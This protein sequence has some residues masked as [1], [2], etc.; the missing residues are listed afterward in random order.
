[1]ST[2]RPHRVRRGFTL[3]ELL[4]VI[5]IIAILVAILMPVFAQVR[6][7][8]RQATVLSNMHQIQLGLAQ[9]QADYHKYPDVLF[10]Y[11][12]DPANA[13]MSKYKPSPSSLGLYPRYVNNW[14]AFTDP[15]NPVT[16]PTKT[17]GTFA[18]NTLIGGKLSTAT[19]HKFFTADAYD[20]S[21][22][23]TGTNKVAPTAY[24]PRYQLNW[25]SL[26]GT[27]PPSG[28]SATDYLRQMRY[29]SMPG[30]TYVTCTTY[31][32][33]NANK[34]IVLWESGTAKV[35]DSSTFLTAGADVAGLSAS[36]DVSNAK[37]WTVRP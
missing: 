18:V 36:G 25:T 11:A 16:D 27:T 6:E 5:A 35:M 20:I 19:A 22:Q 31:H 24:V 34:V 10:G 3:I 32:V 30:D 12:D 4:V 17:V 8:G 9:F 37:F 7:K 26:T 28:V 21:P 23:I 13:D 33:P 1:M 14:Q 29:R 15:N 2:A